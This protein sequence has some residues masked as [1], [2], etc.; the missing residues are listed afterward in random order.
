MKLHKLA[1]LGLPLALFGCPTD[2]GEDTD[3]DLPSET[4]TDVDTDETDTDTEPPPALEVSVELVDGSPDSMVITITNGDESYNFGYGQTAVQA[5]GGSGW[6]GED[7][8][9]GTGSYQLCHPVGMTGATLTYV[10]APGD[11][12][13]GS[14]MLL[15]VDTPASSTPALTYIL[16]GETSGECWVWGD[17]IT[18]YAAFPGGP[19][20]EYTAPM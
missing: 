2:D 10:A 14:T 6:F 11:V 1:I 15:S 17:D 19:C 3:T 18:Y 20:T 13:E 8:Y 9:L 7:C 5:A 12:V 4:D 16:I